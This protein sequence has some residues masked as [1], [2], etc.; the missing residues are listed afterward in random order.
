VEAT[1]VKSL[2]LGKIFGI[3]VH[4]HPTFGLVF[5]WALYQWGFGENAGAMP[6]LLGCL[7]IALIFLSVLV[8]E[9]GH[10]A[11]AQHFGNRVLDVTLWPFGGVARIEQTP[12][13][14]RGELLIALAGPAMN[15]AIFVALLPIALLIGVIGGR[16][17]LF[18]SSDFLNRMTLPGLVG[19]LAVTNLLIMLFNLIPAFPV[20]GGRVLRAMLTPLT[21]RER[22]TT[23]AVWVGVV[24]AIVIV[25]IGIVERSWWLIVFGV[26]IVVA[27]NAE[28]RS[29]RVE[30]AMRRMTVGQYALW[31]GGGVGPDEPLTFALRGGPR[32]LVVTDHGK[33][34]GML[35]Q[36][37]LLNG[38]QGGLAGRVVADVMDRTVPRA[39]VNDSVYD[40]QLEMA[41]HNCWAVPVIEDDTYRG[42]FTAERFVMVY[43]T[44]APG[45]FSNK[46]TIPQEW[47]QA[48]GD[49]VQPRKKN[50]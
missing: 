7:F 37:Q 45:F 16:D 32:N 21:D 30:S 17:A 34:L 14:P 1:H 48:I 18:P 43:R 27:A 39:N 10:A 38:L 3:D 49:I 26:F 40:V 46:L 6:L 29:I 4:I 44:V 35:W 24:L 20:D 50:I 33:V 23:I 15:L 25:A 36:S 42:I 9:L 28:G 19:Y 5:L 11:M 22:A 31:D 2:K 13:K 8:H 47:R 12:E 41:R